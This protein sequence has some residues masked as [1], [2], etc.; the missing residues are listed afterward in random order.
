MPDYVRLRSGRLVRPQR[1]MHGVEW[2]DTSGI[3]FHISPGEWIR[4]RRANGFEI[5]DLLEIYPHEGASAQ[6]PSVTLEWA[7]AWAVAYRKH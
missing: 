3:E 6:P 5:E 4:L 2:P 7:R 1:N